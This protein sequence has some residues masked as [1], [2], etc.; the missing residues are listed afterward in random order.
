M[1]EKE[2]AQAFRYFAQSFLDTGKKLRSVQKQMSHLFEILDTKFG[3]DSTKESLPFYVNGTVWFAAVAD[4]AQ[5]LATL[6]NSM[7]T[8]CN[9]ACG[10]KIDTTGDV[11]DLFQQ[12]RSWNERN[13]GKY[14]ESAGENEPKWN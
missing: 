11:H 10:R 2:F 12:Q 4:I 9:K 7:S 6:S 1:D 3:G 13:H 14:F 8:Q 5:N